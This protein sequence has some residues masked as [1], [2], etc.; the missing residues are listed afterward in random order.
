MLVP[1]L[2]GLLKLNWVG[3]Y[4]RKFLDRIRKN[5]VFVHTAKYERILKRMYNHISL[6]FA[7]FPTSLNI[8]ISYLQLLNI[9]VIS[10]A[11]TWALFPTPKHVRYFQLLNI[12]IISNSLTWALFPTL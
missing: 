6:K 4:L 11:L 2:Q 10:N 12:S 3:W 5:R 8:N 1:D 7:L 9:S